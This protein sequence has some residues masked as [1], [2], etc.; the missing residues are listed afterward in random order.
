MGGIYSQKQGPAVKI[1]SAILT[2]AP[3]FH[4]GVIAFA[5]GIG[6]YFAMKIEPG[7]S[8]LLAGFAGF[9]IAALWL[10][11][12]G[13]ALAGLALLC[14]L[15]LTGL[16][17]AQWHSRA[18]HAPKLPHYERSYTVT[19][20]VEAIEKSGNK[21]RLRLR[22]LDMGTSGEMPH[23]IRL[24][25]TTG[26]TPAPGATIRLRA[27]AKAPPGPVLPGGYDPARAAYF[28]R[29]GGF[30]FT[31]GPAEIL[32][33]ADLPLADH[34][35]RVWVRWRYDLAERIFRQSPAGTAGL[36]AALITGVRKYIPQEQTD[37]LR[38]SG[39]AHILAI[40]GLHMGLLAG[41]VFGGVSLVLAC[42]PRLARRIDVRKPA[43]V[44]GIIAATFYLILSGA[45]VATQRAF[46]MAA[47]VF[48]AVILDRRA[49]SLRSVGVAAVLTLWLHPESLVSV[50]FQMSFAAVT[51]L[52]VTYQAWQKYRPARQ[53]RG[54]FRR[55]LDF[56]TS[57]TVTS[58][59]AGLAT[60]GFALFHFNRIA[61]YGLL[62]NVIAM[63][64]FT[65]A[66]M[67]LAIISLISMS[68]GLEAIPLAA[69]G[70]SLDYILRSADWV[71]NM[72]GAL[73]YAPSAH[74][75]M[76]PLFA[77]AFTAICIGRKWIK[78][79]GLAGMVIC[80][81]LWHGTPQPDM[82]I[83]DSGRVAFWQ[84]D[85]LLTDGT[86]ADRYGREQFI[87]QAGREGAEWQD[88]EDSLA[89]CDALACRVQ[90]N[91]LT[92]SILKHPS[93]VPVECSA[94]DIVILSV[95]EA[96]P[97]ARRGC[98][99]PLIDARSLSQN[100]AVSLYIG[101]TIKIKQSRRG[102]RLWS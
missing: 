77:I 80:L 32:P 2:Y 22:V 10:R 100:G 8:W 43:A 40:S 53:T 89:K 69:M 57:L 19:G 83:S 70:W 14:L 68:V 27:A 5:A 45:S 54:L 55:S 101:E 60:A 67:P 73:F 96:G 59:V 88:Y 99:V 13:R 94:A 48:L 87:R 51:A 97:V 62:G 1:W 56:V 38:A 16:L 98:Q 91:S 11:S 93:E 65:L 34:V 50:G 86:R 44:I 36:Q 24:R 46:I 52:V 58:F 72:E 30:G 17:R 29:I 82:R 63:P 75:Y 102:R 76:L 78:L 31:Y 39:L 25:L 41:S 42:I 9:L 92:V 33:E 28:G 23:R 4:A 66:V 3:G 64:V 85:R 37:D 74:S 84:A 49:I 20:W 95:R 6:L 71:A 35:K 79:I 21:D 90:V 47:I 81:G 15:V 7:L 18:V 12:G 61:R 26:D